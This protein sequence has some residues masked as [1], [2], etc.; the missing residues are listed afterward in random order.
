MTQSRGLTPGPG[1]QGLV[2]L[3]FSPPC[4]SPRAKWDGRH[5]PVRVGNSGPISRSRLSPGAAHLLGFYPAQR[6]SSQAHQTFQYIG[7]SPRALPED[8]CGHLLRSN[9]IPCAPG[10]SRLGDKHSPGSHG[11]HPCRARM[12]L[13]HSDGQRA[14]PRRGHLEPPKPFLLRSSGSS[15]IQQTLAEPIPC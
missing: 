11:L 8:G 10:G 12:C 5:H 13:L 15:F 9:P 7:V 1:P 3:T 6:S 2:S 4:R 14:Q